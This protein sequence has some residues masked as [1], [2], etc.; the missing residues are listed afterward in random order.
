MGREPSDEVA[1]LRIALE[2]RDV[3]GMAK[4]ILMATEGIGPQAAFDVLVRASQNQNRKL[5]DVAEEIVARYPDY[6][7]APV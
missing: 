3:I 7:D 1:H 5:H 6:G 2:T 4:G